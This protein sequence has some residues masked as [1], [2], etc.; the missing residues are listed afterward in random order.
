[1]GNVPMG[2]H[3]TGLK[4]SASTFQRLVNYVFA[5]YIEVFMECY[6][7]DIEVHSKTL[8]DHI[9]HLVL[10]FKRIAK[11]NLWIK[12]SKCEFV[13]SEIKFLGHTISQFFIRPSQDNI[14]KLLNFGVPKDKKTCRAFT[15]LAAY[16]NSFQEN[17]AVIAKPLNK[18]AAKNV[19]KFVWTQECQEAYETLR[20]E[21]KKRFLLVID[22]T[23][24]IIV[25]TD[26]SNIGIGGILSQEHE[27]VELPVRI[28]SKALSEAE[29]RYPTPE[30]EIMAIV[31]TINHFK[32][33]LLGREFTVRSDHQP[34]K[35][36]ASVK[37]MSQRLYRWWM[38]IENYH[39]IIT[40]RPGKKHG[41][42]DAISRL[43]N[44]R[45][46]EQDGDPENDTVVILL[47]QVSDQVK[48]NILLI[49][50]D[51][52]NPNV[53]DQASDGDIK[54]IKEL[55]LTHGDTT[56]P[57]DMPVENRVQKRFLQ[58]YND[59]RIRDETVFYA[60]ETNSGDIIERYVVPKEAHAIV[61]EKLHKSV[62]SGHLG[63]QKT[64]DRIN[65]RFWWPFY[66]PMVEQFIADCESCQKIKRGT[67]NRAPLKY[68]TPTRPLEL[69]T[70]DD[71]GPLPKTKS[72]NTYIQVIV[73][74]FTKL[75][76]GYAKPE[77]T[78][79][80][81]AKIC[82][83]FMM[84]YGVAE[85]ILTD[86]GSNF[87]SELM[88]EL[89]E[90]LDIRKIRSSAGHAMGDGQSERMVRTMK[91]MI[92]AYVNE[93]QDDWDENLD[94]LFFA[95]NSAVHRSTK[96]SPMEAMFHR[97]IKIPID[98]F[99]KA[100]D[101]TQ[102]EASQIRDLDLSLNV[103]GYAQEVQQELTRLYELIASNRDITM[104]KAKIL[105]DRTVRAP[106]MEIGD[107]VLL[108]DNKPKKGENL[109]I[110][111]K[112]TGPFVIEYI[113]NDVNYALKSFH[114]K[115]VIYTVAHQNLLKK[116]HGP[117]LQHAKF[118][119]TK[120]RATKERDGREIWNTQ[121]SVTASGE[122]VDMSLITSRTRKSVKSTKN[123]LV[124]R[125]ATNKRVPLRKQVQLQQ[126]VEAVTTRRSERTRSKPDYFK[127]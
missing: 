30:K 20:E 60:P 66:R 11:H 123:K 59:L 13:K 9:T 104:D 38:E 77:N 12:R 34:L 3:A 73:D 56:P 54:W 78:A 76:K 108:L 47:L 64:L 7:D 74:H 110:K 51:L 52:D 33:Y 57:A 84:V 61:M 43:I 89:M 15:G 10:V 85:Q 28:Y 21:I 93:H 18:A 113:L 27:G 118:K 127:P 63:A 103:I 19:K 65:E 41:N 69:I 81:S 71:A 111:K 116:W 62:F 67:R 109:S 115:R 117:A 107:F 17:F 14:D 72:G 86:Q 46:E 1:M 97:K 45:F 88:H 83:A 26:A 53:G 122:A 48:D 100:V 96:I 82:L 112:W 125:A 94:Q 95:Y 70:M 49:F 32:Y 31:K 126:L 79:K 87:E 90:L 44:T 40:Y 2:S 121:D 75:S 105:Y 6:V 114:T 99:Y 98:I 68:I 106:R 4:N 5:D 37:D 8:R 101:L 25:D 42:A 23:K 124:T 58:K 119:T 55:L 35:Y 80:T 102:V 36:L 29:Q 120:H 16:Y 92:T 24:P 91:E 39:A 22:P 50:T